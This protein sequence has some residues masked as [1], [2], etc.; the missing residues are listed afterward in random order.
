MKPMLAC[1]VFLVALLPALFAQAPATSGNVDFSAGL[2]AFERDDYATAL[3]VWRPLAEKG[4]AAAQYS[5]GFMYD[6][7][8][9]VP[10]DYAEAARWFRKAADQGDARAQYSI[11]FMYAQGQGVPQDHAEAARW[12]RKAA[13][14]GNK[15]SVYPQME[16]PYQLPNGFMR[17]FEAATIRVTSL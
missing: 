8:K 10:Q 1:V 5:I 12:Y 11:G 9:G 13:D 16:R 7:G 4:D 15:H 2:K 3:N 17:R 14:Q 6:Q